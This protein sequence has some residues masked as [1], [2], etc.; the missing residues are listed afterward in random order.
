MTKKL[1][2]LSILILANLNAM[3]F[4]SVVQK[5]T[6]KRKHEIGMDATFFI[7]QFVNFSNSSFDYDPYIVTYRYFTKNFNIRFGFTAIYSK[8]NSKP[9]SSYVPTRSKDNYKSELIRLGV[10][11][12]KILSKSWSVF[13]GI[14]IRQYSSYS[15]YSNQSQIS[16]YSVGNISKTNSIGIAPFLGAKLH[17]NK[18]INLST[19]TSMPFYYLERKTRNY[20]TPYYS[21]L[22]K[23]NDDGHKDTYIWELHYILPV[24]VIFAFNL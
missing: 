10:E 23:K 18:R 6:L 19:E 4:I 7:K 20:Y 5:D 3:S 12:Q 17:I 2:F 1:K 8:Q 11:K 21:S 14:D 13:Y 9:S 16:N 15:N 22:P 24:F